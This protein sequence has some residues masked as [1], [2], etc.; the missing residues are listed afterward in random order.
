MRYSMNNNWYFTEQYTKELLNAS[1]GSIKELTLVRLPHTVKELPLNYCQE[2]DYQM[3]SGYVHFLYAKEEW[4][5]KTILLTFGAAAHEAEVFCNEASLI[6]HR[7]GYTAFTVDLTEHLH[8]G[9]ENR[10]TVRLDSRESLNIPPFGHVIDY[11]TFGGLYR[12]VTLEVKEKSYFKDVFASGSME[13]MLKVEIEVCQPEDCELSA[14]V[15]DAE[16]RLVVELV[17]MPY[18][19]TL[20]IE[21]RDAK[22]WDTKHPNLY[23]L[24]LVLWKSGEAIDERKICFGFRSVAFTAQGFYLN[25]KKLKLR[26]LNR[27]QSWPYIGYAAPD[28]AQALDAEI[29]K[30]ELGCNAVRTSHYPQSHAFLNRCDELGLLVFTEIPGWQHIGDEAWKQQAVKNVEEMIIEYRNHPS[31]F[32]WGVRIN[33]SPD[34]NDFYRQTNETAHRLDP[35]RPTGG[36]R[37]IKKSHL[38]EDVYTYNDFYHTGRNKGCE[39]KKQITSDMS[40]GYLVSEYNGHMFPTKTY[41]WEEKRC[42]HALRHAAVLD[43]VRRQKDIAGSFGWC[44]FDYNTHQDF[45]SGDKICYH[46]VM[47]A[48]RNPKL[49]AF[50]YAAEGLSRPV[51]EISSSMDIGEHPAGSLGEVYAFTNADYIELYRNGEFTARFMPGE[52][53]TH[54]KHPPI[55]I[56]DTIGCLL[57]TKEGYD[58]KTAKQVKKCLYGIAK[59][60]QA[61]LPP[62]V[63]LTAGSLMLTKHFTYAKGE[64][65]FGKYIGNWGDKMTEWRFVAIK[66]GKQVAGVCKGPVKKVCLEVKADTRKL[67]ETDTWDM[68]T[69][70]IRVVDEKGNLLPYMNRALTLKTEGAVELVGPCAVALSGGMAGTYVKTR[71]ESGEGRLCITMQGIEPVEIIFSV[72]KSEEEFV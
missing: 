56:D 10:I 54:L 39:P 59:H 57:E 62:G 71:G 67:M 49:A 4:K 13:G 12:G 69:V 24:Q 35:T 8:Y 41:D 36:V 15:R 32:L 22:L 72:Q 20:D 7:C 38:F 44:M 60:G 30:N 46:G 21:V 34:D 48:F 65:L 31:I 17:P 47:D 40:K 2:T 53:Y 16:G 50:V 18:Q 33:E 55:P 68:A 27:H 9:E 5:G 28:R 19:K 37:C 6:V 25:G 43:E 29:L 45:G 63:L 58:K 42:E 3:E 70:R 52:K 66:N 23:N 14:Q 61:A 64:E 26:G 51:L 11:M 1:A